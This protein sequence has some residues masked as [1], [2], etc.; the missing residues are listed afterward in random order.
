MADLR[1]ADPRCEFHYPF[2]WREIAPMLLSGDRD[3]VAEAVAQLEDRD[4]ALVDHLANRPCCSC[5]GGGGG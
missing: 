1:G 5:D 3:Q 4:R 2:E